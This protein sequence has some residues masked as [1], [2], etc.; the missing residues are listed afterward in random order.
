LVCISN[1]TDAE[2]TDTNNLTSFDDDG[3]SL[4]T[5]Y[6][7]TGVNGSGRTYVPGVGEQEQAPH[8]QTQ[9]VQ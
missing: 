9:M 7:S 8:Q 2:E 4:G 5:G 6:S 3:F 1:R